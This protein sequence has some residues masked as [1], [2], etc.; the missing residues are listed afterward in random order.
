[1]NRKHMKYAL[2]IFA[3][4]AMNAF[5][6]IAPFTE[7]PR[8][9][10]DVVYKELAAQGAWQKHAKH[11]W[12]FVPNAPD[13][14][15][16]YRNGQW[17][18]SNAGWLWRGK[19][20]WS[21][22][23]D[24][25]GAWIYEDKK[26][27]WVP[28]NKWHASSVLWQEAGDLLGW[29]PVMLDEFQE[30]LDGMDELRIPETWTV[31]LRTNLEHPVDQSLMVNDDM[32][33]AFLLKA[34]ASYHVFRSYR[35][36]ERAGPE[37]AKIWYKTAEPPIVYEIFTLPTPDTEPPPGAPSKN[38]YMYR[39]IFAQDKE[40][41]FRRIAVNA[42]GRKTNDRASVS[43]V[44]TGLSEEEKAKLEKI[45]QIRNPKIEAVPADN[46]PESALPAPDENV[47]SPAS[48]SQPTN[49]GSSIMP[50]RRR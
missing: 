27:K 7:R 16:P 3:F 21:W 39:P 40:G 9:D 37:P 44:L 25:Y 31:T 18:Y 48:E 14:W 26:W 28:G 6:G 46:K 19:E 4:A 12:V 20:P 30:V 33:D 8:I 1:M 45:Q 34:D 36:F 50:S 23:T 43:Q 42:E 15:K 13:S 49:T 24:H 11:K 29:R 22:V 35:E 41:I 17:V 38:V 10:F 47:K 5:A 2:L 32:R